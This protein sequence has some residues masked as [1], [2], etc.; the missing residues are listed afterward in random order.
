MDLQL[1]RYVPAVGSDS[2]HRKE[3][4]LGNLLVA[5]PLGHIGDNIL[6]PLAQDL[7]LV[8]PLRILTAGIICNRRPAFFQFLFYSLYSRDKKIVLN[9][10]MRGKVLLTQNDVHKDGI[11]KIIVLFR[12]IPDYHI[13]QFLELVSDWLMLAGKLRNSVIFP[14]MSRRELLH[15]CK[16]YLILILHVLIDSLHIFIVETDDEHCDVIG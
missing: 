7:G 4:S 8:F 11:E 3:E 5:H 1:A 9:L 6:L 10:A 15:V 13:L 12:V 14:Q 2:V 16:Y